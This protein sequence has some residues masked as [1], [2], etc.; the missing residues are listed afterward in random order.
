ML[1]HNSITNEEYQ[2]INNIG[3][4]T[5]KLDLK[6]LA[7]KGLLEPKGRGKGTYYV[8]GATIK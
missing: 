6:D 4:T 8:I 2:K 1:E 5:A 3:R 7:E